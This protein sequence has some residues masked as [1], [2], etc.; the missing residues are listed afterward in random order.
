MAH[1]ITL[2]YRDLMEAQESLRLLS[3]MKLP[4][5]SSIKV[6]RII[7]KLQPE[8]EAFNDV[9]VKVLEEIGD[10]TPT[11]YSIPSND[12]ERI[13]QL[14]EALEPTLETEI[15]IVA[16]KLRMSDVPDSIEPKILVECFWM[17]DDAEEV[18]NDQ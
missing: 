2:T 6:A 13:R 11:G 14:E 8:F 4:K 15:E 12:F 9:R 5:G 18:A 16:P 10:K 3:N 7:R 1:S 17:I